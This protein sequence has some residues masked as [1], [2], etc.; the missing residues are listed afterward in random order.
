MDEGGFK[1][2]GT[3]GEIGR[4]SES[5]YDG[6]SLILGRKGTIDKPFL[7]DEPFWISDVVYYTVPKTEIGTEYLGYLSYLI[8]FEHFKYGSTLPNI[9][10]DDYENMG[11][12]V[13]PPSEQKHI[14]N[15]LDK[16]T[17]QIDSLT[18]CS[19]TQIRLLREYRQSLISEVVTGKKRITE[20]MI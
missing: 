6:P 3:G 19:E 9:G 10:K 5:M 1:V 15:Y 12:P 2:F 18:K 17:T 7:V 11:F 13:P 20:D 4:S 8:P 16:K 14:A